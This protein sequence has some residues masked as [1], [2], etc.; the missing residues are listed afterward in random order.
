MYW[1]EVATPAPVLNTPDFHA[2]F[3]GN[4]GNTI[5]LES[6][7]FIALKH[8]RFE[9]LDQI[10]PHILQIQWPQYSATPL[11]VDQRFC[12]SI[13]FSHPP[14]PE[15]FSPKTILQHMESRVGIPYVWGGN[16]ANGVPEMLLYYPPQQPLDKQT[17]I[18][19]TLQGLDCSGLLFEATQG[20][21][22]RNTS[23]LLRFGKSLS[24]SEELKPLDMIIYPGHVLFVRDENTIIESKSPYGV[25]ICSLQQ[26]MEELS[27]TRRP[28]L[29]PDPRENKDSYFTIRRF[30]TESG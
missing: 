9:V 28:L 16:W 7:E 18:F 13:P 15:P 27:Q 17:E 2:V 14:T 4:S 8:M 25:R 10:K 26:R 24:P 1:I 19:W 21:T 20:A 11:Y 12:Q 3:G 22:P 23:H 6:F 29:Q 30:I 5:A